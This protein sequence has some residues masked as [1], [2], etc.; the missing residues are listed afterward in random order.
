MHF[1]PSVSLFCLCSP[2]FQALNGYRGTQ[3]DNKR[4]QP[5]LFISSIQTNISTL[6]QDNKR[7]HPTI[8]ISNIQTNIPALFQ[9]PQTVFLLVAVCCTFPFLPRHTARKTNRRSPLQ[10]SCPQIDVAALSTPPATLQTFFLLAR[11]FHLFLL[12]RPRV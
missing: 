2:Y 8:F 12:T 11:T 7:T 4:T 9:I 10:I 5:R 3:Q 1:L 6:L